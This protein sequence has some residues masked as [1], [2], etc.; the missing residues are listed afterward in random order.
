MTN[1]KRYFRMHLRA[2]SRPIIYIFVTVLVLSFLIGIN[3]QPSSYYDFETETT[4]S[5]YK[6][7]LYIP[8][9]LMCILAYVLPVMEFSFFKK[10]INLDCAYALPISRR[11]MGTVHY[12]VGLIML[13]GAFTLSYL[14]NF[15]LLLSRGTGWFNFTPMI[16]HYFLCLLL[17]F[18]LYSL[19][20]F[21]F[22]EANTKGDGI[23][24]IVLYSFVFGLVFS[25][26]ARYSG[27]SLSP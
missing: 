27:I 12:L 13:F 1:F 3:A 26:F 21:V 5:C 25:A 9:T 19:M 20:V 15:A 23:W 22:N 7:T 4:A 10:R 8:V 14:L 16:A 11:A 2:N 6:S 18:S 17:G 24:F